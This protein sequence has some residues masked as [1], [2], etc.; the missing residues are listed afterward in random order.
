MNTKAHPRTFSHPS[1][2]AGRKD[3]A[4]T[5][6]I[7]SADTPPPVSARGTPRP[8]CTAQFQDRNTLPT[9]ARSPAQT[10]PYNDACALP[11]GHTM[12]LRPFL[13]N[14]W[15]QFAALS[16][17]L[18]PFCPAGPHPES[19]QRAR[20]RLSRS[21]SDRSLAISSLLAGGSPVPTPAALPRAR[22]SPLSRSRNSQR[23][24][25]TRPTRRSADS[26]SSSL[27]CLTEISSRF[28]LSSLAPPEAGRIF[29]SEFRRDL[30]CP[31]HPCC[32]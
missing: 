26:E 9:L 8:A 19:R 22:L 2:L 5:S 28:R 14:P 11:S 3:S 16:R 15:K 4:R 32:P 12:P 6:C 31:S 21:D 23:F 20:R 13:A 29:Q 7:A 17:W 27:L 24:P 18:R 30:R 25:L 1:V 10:P